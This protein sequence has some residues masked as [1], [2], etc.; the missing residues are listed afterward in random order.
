[1]IEISDIYVYLYIGGPSQI[2]R[3]PVCLIKLGKITYE[4][5]SFYKFFKIIYLPP[6]PT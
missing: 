5:S 3:Q 2:A 1:M 4:I 6:H